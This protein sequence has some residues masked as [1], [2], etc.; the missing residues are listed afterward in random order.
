MYAHARARTCV[1][2]RVCVRACDSVC[3][4]MQLVWV[5]LAKSKFYMFN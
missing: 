4:S 1:R 5:R 2:V 3:D